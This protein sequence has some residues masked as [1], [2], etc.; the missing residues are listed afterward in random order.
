MITNRCD[1]ASKGLKQEMRCLPDPG[2]KRG[3]NDTC[4]AGCPIH[5]TWTSLW[6]TQEQ[7]ERRGAG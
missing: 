4:E 3:G 2:P 1:S 7:D 5:R 6:K